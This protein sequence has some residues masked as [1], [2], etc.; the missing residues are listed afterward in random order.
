MQIP[1]HFFFNIDKPETIFL[2]LKV[3]FFP[4]ARQRKKRQYLKISIL[5]HTT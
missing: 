5:K 2:K 3:F 1:I 4:F